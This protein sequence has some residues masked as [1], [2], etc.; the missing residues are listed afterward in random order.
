MTKCAS[1]DTAILS[2]WSNKKLT[3]GATFSRENADSVALLN[4]DRFCTLYF[5][6]LRTA[7]HTHTLH[8]SSLLGPCLR[9]SIPLSGLLV[10]TPWVVSSVLPHRF[11][12]NRIQIRSSTFQYALKRY[13]NSLGFS[14]NKMSAPTWWG[15]QLR[16]K[17]IPFKIW[18]RFWKILYQIVYEQFKVK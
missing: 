6:A 15:F 5:I 9:F 18:R 11:S 7:L 10:H 13:L 2:M 17:I 1:F 3:A 4:T 16:R 12:H 14:Y 8:T